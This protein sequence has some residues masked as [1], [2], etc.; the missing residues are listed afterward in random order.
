MSFP[1]TVEWSS[2]SK[3]LQA[4]LRQRVNGVSFWL[5]PTVSP[6]QVGVVPAHLVGAWA[7]APT[8]P[9][10]VAS[11]LA[12][13]SATITAPDG[14]A[15]VRL[16][17][18]LLASIAGRTASVLSF[19][20]LFMV[21]LSSAPAGT[22]AGALVPV[23]F[24]FGDTVLVASPQGPQR[25]KG[26]SPNG[27]RTAVG[28]H[29]LLSR[30]GPAGFS[31]NA[32]FVDVTE[33]WWGAHP[34][35][36]WG[37]YWRP[38]TRGRLQHL[39]VLVWTGGGNPML[40]F[41]AVPDAAVRAPPDSPS[42][43]STAQPEASP[44]PAADIV[45]IRPPPG[46][47][48]F[49]YSPDQRGFEAKEHD[50]TTLVNLARY[51]LSPV[52][53]PTF[54]ALAAAGLRSAELLADQVQPKAM[55]PRVSPA[56]PMS[57][58]KLLDAAGHVRNEAFTDSRANAFRPVGLEAAVN[59]TGAA[60]VLF[61]PLGF[62]AS[63]GDKERGIKGNPQGGYEAVATADLKLTIQSAL[64]T[65]WNA[66]AIA[67][68]KPLPP[69]ARNRELWVGGHSEGNRTVWNCLAGNSRDID[70]VV[71][72]DSDTL[73][74]GIATLKQAGQKRPPN[75]PLHAFVVLTPNNGDA[76]G[77]PASV[78]ITLRALRKSNVLVTVLPAFD[79]RAGYWHITPP[80]IG[81]PYLKFVLEKWEIPA[82][83]GV[84]AKTLLDVSAASAGNWNFL[85]FHEL[86]IFG[87][88]LVQ[89]A[90]SGGVV[91]RPSVRTF[92]EMA[93]GPPDPRPP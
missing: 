13:Q 11:D 59:R 1:V 71:S 39:R 31:V 4:R 80:P 90:A 91:A 73:G 88:D 75:K 22:G 27:R 44:P 83:P 77:L 15:H 6:V 9:V 30:T 41:A 12:R 48:S 67:R 76:N 28:L 50:D 37:W 69:Q 74:E 86:A 66:N 24:S 61:L 23:Q 20:Q 16:D 78:D 18:D 19:R 79:A 62:S 10:G 38:E 92:F 56:D 47:N 85:F 65:L 33:L 3:S 60:H 29:P 26:P 42:Q 87:G 54:Q 2:R 68:D 57:M 17:F 51:L 36:T 25:V 43:S 93:L 35:T 53:E 58:M 63:E 5:S 84:G 14:P 64:S 34:D 46:S 70:R 32:E 7:T 89:P 82:Q 49:P 72:F 45:F 40:W 8:T 52:S 81:N 21:T 55:A